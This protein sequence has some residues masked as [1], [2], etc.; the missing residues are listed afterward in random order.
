LCDFFG[1]SRQAYYKQVR[2]AADNSLKDQLVAELVQKARRSNKMMGGKKVYH[3]YYDAIHA[4][5]SCLGRDKFFHLLARRGLLIERRRKYATTTQSRHR[6]KKYEN[7]MKEFKPAAPHQAWVGDITYL[8]T[9]QGFV[10]LFLM[11]DAYSRKIVGWELSRGLG[12]EAALKAV[13]MAIRQCRDTKNVLHHT[14]RGFQYCSPKYVREVESKGIQ[15]SMGEAGNC[16]DNAMAERVNGILKGEYG[17]DGTFKDLEQALAAT[18]EGIKDYNE[19]RPHWSLRLQIPSV[20][21]GN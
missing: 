11:T 7:L 5:N 16:Y 13:R 2:K 14:D 3:K 17:L 1:F 19:Q 9:R 4:T 20:I 21:H 12:I 18:K 8:R 10:Y 15:M 6:F